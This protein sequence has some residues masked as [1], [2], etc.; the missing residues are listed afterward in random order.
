M[1]Y[2]WEIKSDF[3]QAE[4]D[5]LANEISISNVLAKL[6]VVRGIKTFEEAKTYFRP[7]IDELHD[8]FL[9]KDMN[10]AVDRIEEAFGSGEKLMI[11]GDYDVDGTTA[12]SLV[13]GYFSNVYEQI[14]YYIPDRYK[15]GYGISYDGIDHA[16]AQAFL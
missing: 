1:E 14:E 9:M 6:L 3:D 7:A 15:E 16:I 13:Y 10:K 5:K 11:Y 2:K 4:V 12:V 8:P